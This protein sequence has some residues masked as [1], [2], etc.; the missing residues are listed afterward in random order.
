M[1][2]RDPTTITKSP[3]LTHQLFRKLCLKMF[4]KKQRLLIIQFA[5]KEVTIPSLATTDPKIVRGKQYSY[6]FIQN[7]SG[8]RNRG[9]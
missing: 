1:M 4:E 3:N 5:M 8:E 9:K 7:G 2:T 6:S